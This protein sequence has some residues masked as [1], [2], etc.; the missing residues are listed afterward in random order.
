M[1]VVEIRQL[2]KQLNEDYGTTILI[3][4]HILTEVHQLATHYGIIH[5]GRLISE[6]SAAQLDEKCQEYLLIKVSDH[7]I[8]TTILENELETVAYEVLPKGFIKLYS[9]IDEPALV[10]KT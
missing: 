1:G 9:Y 7:E 8:A 6:I 10:V 4:S 5:H 3:S 2:L